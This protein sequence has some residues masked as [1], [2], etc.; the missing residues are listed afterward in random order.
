MF[1]RNF[2]TPYICLAL[3]QRAHSSAGLEHPDR[4]VGR[5]RGSIQ[6]KKSNASSGRIAQLV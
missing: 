1:V 3:A 4:Q 6:H 2:K 5:V